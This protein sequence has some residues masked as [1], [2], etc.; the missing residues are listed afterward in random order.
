MHRVVVEDLV[1]DLV[2]HHDQ[3]VLARDVGDLPKYPLGVHSARR[4]VG[5]DHNDRLGVRRDLRADVLDV[6]EPATLLVAEVVHR[7]ATCQRR[8]RGPER[9]VRGRHQHLVTVVEHGLQR[10][11]DQLADPVAEPDVVDV[12]DVDAPLLVVLHDCSSGREQAL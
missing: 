1:V 3:A 8:R 5:V 11:G 7:T 2:G 12:H 10:Q 9:V 6:G 4:I